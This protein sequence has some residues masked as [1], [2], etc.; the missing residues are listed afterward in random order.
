M[1]Q[2]DCALRL[3]E[4]NHRNLEPIFNATFGHLPTDKASDLYALLLIQ[5]YHG[6]VGRVAGLMSDPETQ[7]AAQYFARHHERFSAGD[8]ALEIGRASCREKMLSLNGGG[9][10]CS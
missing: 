3:L 6:G 10:L 9:L 8:I 5:A 7:G 2:V 1:A 4:Q